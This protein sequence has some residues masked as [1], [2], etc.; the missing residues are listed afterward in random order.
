VAGE[1]PQA[2]DQALAPGVGVIAVHVR[3]PDQLFNSMD[4]SPFHQRELDREAEAFILSSAK[5]LHGN[6]P[7]A[8][9]VYLGQG[10]VPGD[11]GPA[12]GIGDAIRVHFSRRARQSRRELRQMLR[13]G[14]TSLVIGLVFLAAS[15]VGSDLVAR[16]M[17]GRPLGLVL[18]E[19]LVISGWV[20]MWRPMEVFLYDWWPIRR[21]RR[22]FDRLGE[23]AVH[24]IPAGGEA[25][26]SHGRP[27]D[28][29]EASPRPGA[30][31]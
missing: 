27:A 17:E 28:G 4:P 7:I 20:A 25:I 9:L 10:A 30:P 15:L 31:H 2:E 3:E 19:S 16:F 8:L 5:E 13:R 29:A 26:G 18:R 24:V 14:R 1:Y 21:E 6:V 22:I 11:E 23:A 12:I